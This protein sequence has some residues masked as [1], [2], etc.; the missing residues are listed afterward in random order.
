MP[1]LQVARYDLEAIASDEAMKLFVRYLRIDTTNP[2][3]RTIEAVAV[4]E[5]ALRLRG[6]PVHRDRGRP[7]AADRR[8]AA[9]GAK[10]GEGLL[11]L[12]HMDV[13][14]ADD[15]WTYPPFGAEKGNG[16]EAFYL[17]G[18]GAIDMKNTGIAHFLAIAALHRDGIVPERDLVFVAEPGEE[19]FTPEVGIGW[20]VKSRPDLLEG[21]TD[22][23]TEGGVNEVLT[24][25]LDRFGIETF[26]KASV[27]MT[28]EAATREPLEA[29][30]KLLEAKD[31]EPPLEAPP[32]GGRVPPVHRPLPG[33]R[34]GAARDEPP[35]FSRDEAVA[36][37]APDVYRS[38]LKDSI[39]SGAVKAKSGGGFELEVAWTLLPGSSPEAAR[40]QTEAWASSRGLHLRT[41]FVT[42][43]AVISP[44]EG[45]AWD[46]LVRALQLD[47]VQAEVGAYILS[48][49]YT[50]SS[51]LRAEG[52]RAYGVSPFAVNIFDAA[53]A[54]GPNERI[55]MPAFLEGVDRTKRIVREFA[56][57]P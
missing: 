1:A 26:Q 33:R 36:R 27:G 50:N 46:A 41:R 15:R 2:P 4:L 28:V 37:S 48:G 22:V 9:G 32:G 16:N 56:T 5:G 18:R 8:G 42:R 49:A 3:G 24:T 34:L 6:A 20:V 19:T 7:G 31:A 57:S 45:P 47:P 10:A 11:L 44:Q 52:Y 30:R 21:V 53:R 13:V 23:F 54:H 14:P 29:F 43:D 51:F 17:F 55:L 38:L 39:Y 40:R 25:D 35:A 12:H